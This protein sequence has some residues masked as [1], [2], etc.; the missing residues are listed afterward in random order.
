MTKIQCVIGNSADRKVLMGFAPAALLFRHSF[1]DILNEDTG[2]GYQ[3]RFNARH[4]QDFRR[5]I[6]LPQS[7]TPP[8][9][10][11]LRPNDEG[12]W[13]VAE[14]GDGTAVLTIAE[15]AGKILAQ[16]DC[17]HRL[18][19]MDELDVSLPF[20]IY[21]GL[22]VREETEV[23]LTI[24][25]KA[26]GLSTSLLDFHDAQIADDLAKDR[27]E[28]FAALHLHNEEASPWYRR[29]DLGGNS[30]SGLLRR[31]SLRTMQKAAARFIN[32]SKI[33]KTRSPE[34]CATV[35]LNFWRAVAEV[36]PDQWN[37]SRKHILTKGIG[38][39]ALSD[40]AADLYIEAPDQQ[41]VDRRYFVNALGDFVHDID[42]TSKGMGKG[43]GG[44]E[45]ANELR[46]RIRTTRRKKSVRL[47][48]NG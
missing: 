29:L 25:G 33:L 12:A 42:W 31:A 11:N 37:D 30:T 17:Q 4:S 14:R 19:H 47:V 26:K 39:Y 2:Q 38:V 18:G 24:N 5:Y 8:L 34:H 36:L 43:L 48:S 21:M 6:R 15:A 3:R 44:E 40:L 35:L 41:R 28:L 13:D 46:D 22:T 20:M 10:L 1:A 32:T 7:S 16:V 45:G 23:F 9:T 27:P